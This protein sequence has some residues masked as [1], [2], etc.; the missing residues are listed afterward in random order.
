M[1]KDLIL[2]HNLHL[3]VKSELNALKECLQAKPAFPDGSPSSWPI[4]R[5]S[6]IA[7]HASHECPERANRHGCRRLLKVLGDHCEHQRLNHLGRWTL[8]VFTSGWLTFLLTF[9]SDFDH[10]P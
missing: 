5:A 6:K 2:T 10:I 4:M 8:R 7:T 1:S 9:T 3:E